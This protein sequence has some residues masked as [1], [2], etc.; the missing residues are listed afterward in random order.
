M[1][2][3]EYIEKFK[4]SDIRPLAL[5]SAP[6]GVDVSWCLK[7]I[8]G[9]QIAKK[10]LPTWS[11]VNNIWYPPKLSMEQCSS[12]ATAK[13]KQALAER[14]VVDTN[15][16]TLVDLTGGFGVDF[17]YMA[18]N[19]GKAI[20]VEQ[21]A[22]LCDTA[23]HNFPLLNL[24]QAVIKHADS[25]SSLNTIKDVDIIYIDPARR[26]NTGTKTV[27]ISDCTP[28]LSI[29]QEELFHKA[30]YIIIK[31]SPM[32]DITQA[33]R[34]LDK[35]I[36]IHVIS[37]KG[38]CKELLFVQDATMDSA[39]TIALHCYNLGTDD[40]PFITTKGSPQQVQTIETSCEDLS[41]YI[42]FEP[43]ASIQKA[44][45]QDEFGKHYNLYKLH[46]QSNLFVCNSEALK[47]LTREE[48]GKIPARTFRIVDAGDFSKGSIKKLT[49]NI[50][51][52][53]LTIRNFP[54]S[55]AELRKRMKLKEGGTDYFFATTLYNGKHALLKCIQYHQ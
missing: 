20:Y 47:G 26:S 7:Q 14:L 5:K 9:Y 17:T 29:I 30:H 50:K 8:E 34:T 46:P 22:I 18:Q 35:V 48:K 28:D 6:E 33:L 40:A 21:Q 11:N 4:E 3:E 15:R 54:T 41:G 38:E 39:S 43:N 55:V 51:Q 13:Y 44:G 36:E 12:E 1:T 27:A 52:A 2:N 23:H 19:F 37:V 32:L 45:L 49:K 25:V 10:K 42:L 31:L 24:P 53:N 16:A